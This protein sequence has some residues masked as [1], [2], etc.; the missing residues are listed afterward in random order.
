MKTRCVFC[1]L[2]LDSDQP[3]VYQRVT[4]W[5]RLRKQGGTNAIRLPQRQYE[6]ACGD[7]I[8]LRVRGMATQPQLF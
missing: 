2:E 3:G 8:E 4:G 6:W 7:C 1:N 5:E